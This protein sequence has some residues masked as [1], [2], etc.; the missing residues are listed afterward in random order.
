MTSALD[1]GVNDG[2]LPPACPVEVVP[3]RLLPHL[4][5]TI[6]GPRRSRSWMPSPRPGCRPTGCSIS[7]RRCR[8]SSSSTGCTSRS[9]G[10]RSGPRGCWRSCVRDD[11]ARATSD[12]RAPASP[13]VATARLPAQHSADGARGG[14][15]PVQG[16]LAAG[17]GGRHLVPRRDGRVHRG[18][19]RANCPSPLPAVCPTR[20]PA[21]CPSVR[22]GLDRLALEALVLHE[23]CHVNQAELLC[24]EPTAS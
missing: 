7:I 22:D 9:R 8:P 1:S 10:S 19:K 15:A 13:R 3:L 11:V 21:R 4:D 12:V 14:R 24:R 23:A 2:E 18:F 17:G 16:V 5:S 6:G 20:L